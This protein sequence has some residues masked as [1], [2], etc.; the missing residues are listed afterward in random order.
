MRMRCAS[1]LSDFLSMLA[2]YLG[3]P[4]VLVFEVL[5]TEPHTTLQC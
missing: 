1:K 5:H 4:S 2:P 3:V